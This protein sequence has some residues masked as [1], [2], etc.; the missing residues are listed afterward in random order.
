MKSS[1]N[2]DIDDSSFIDSPFYPNMTPAKKKVT[3]RNESDYLIQL[4]KG[5]KLEKNVSSL[6]ATEADQT[7]NYGERDGKNVMDNEY[8]RNL[9]AIK[10]F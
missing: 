3:W 1:F 2:L 7:L 8:K 9:H 4:T 5:N 10:L 6:T